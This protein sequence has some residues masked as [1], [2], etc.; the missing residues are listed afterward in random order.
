MSATRLARAHSSRDPSPAGLATSWANRSATSRSESSI[1]S[2]RA[3]GSTCERVGRAVSGVL[4]AA[5]SCMAPMVWWQSCVTASRSLEAMG[6][7]PPGL[8]DSSGGAV[9]LSRISSSASCCSSRWA[10]PAPPPTAPDTYLRADGAAPFRG[11]GAP[12][13]VPA[14]GGDG[15]LW[16]STACTSA[17]SLV[18]SVRSEGC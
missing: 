4:P 7:S 15:A 3:N 17:I 10:E 5:G 1:G 18:E 6:V 2:A 9:Q 12:A 11:D 13:L 14:P 8:C 16:R